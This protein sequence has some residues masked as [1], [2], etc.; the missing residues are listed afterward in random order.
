MKGL[1][2]YGEGIAIIM[3]YPVV[4]YSGIYS[5]IIWTEASLMVLMPDIP[6]FESCHLLSCVILVY[7]SY[8]SFPLFTF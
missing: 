8:L 1:M 5:L 2:F 4:F 6:E 7:L 3:R